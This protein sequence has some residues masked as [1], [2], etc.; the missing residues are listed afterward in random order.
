MA[1]SMV[2]FAVISIVLFA[3]EKALAS[4]VSLTRGAKRHRTGSVVGIAADGMTETMTEMLAE[5]MPPKALSAARPSGLMRSESGRKADESS[6]SIPTIVGSL[7][8]V[9]NGSVEDAVNGSLENV[10]NGSLESASSKA[11]DAAK[12]T[13]K[14]EEE[15]VTEGNGSSLTLAAVSEHAH[16]TQHRFIDSS[17]T[18]S[19]GAASLLEL[20]HAHKAQMIPGL[21]AADAV[22]KVMDMA[23]GTTGIVP[24]DYPFACFCNEEGMCEGDAMQTS[25]KMRAGTGSDAP[26]PAMLSAAV[27]IAVLLTIGATSSVF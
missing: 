7:E 24:E 10:F 22:H 25:C 27:K 5:A 19:G 14:A 15:T 2:P 8:N 11:V 13:D 12:T 23:M 21:S 4:P 26:R 1:P 16:E 18:V 17:S 3:Q 6:S 20:D 9:L